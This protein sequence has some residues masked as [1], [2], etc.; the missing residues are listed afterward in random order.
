MTYDAVTEEMI[1]ERYEPSWEA[2]EATKSE[3]PFMEACFYLLKEITQW[4]LLISTS[5][6]FSLSDRNEAIRR[7]LLVRLTKLM[8]LTLRELMAK[9][10]FQQLNISRDAIETMANLIY[11]MDDD[12]TGERYDQ[13]VRNSLIAERE[14]VQDITKNIDNRD[15]R[16]LHIE[17]RMMRSIQKTAKAAGIDDV[18]TLPGR[19]QIGWPKAEDRVRLL[20]PDAYV[21]YRM[22]SGE[23]HGDWTDLYRNHLTF[24]DGDFTPNMNA[25][26]SRPQIPLM[27]VIIAAK[28]VGENLAHFIEVPMAEAIASQFEDINQRAS[29]LD[30]LHEKLLQLP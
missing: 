12:G 4:M 21:A 2:L 1:P 28:F 22:G 13:Y 6:P 27:L 19:R 7:G 5:Q 10:T 11:V 18:T 25:F 14:V 24:K 9:E 26:H 17:Q 8:R 15:D 29:K 3:A 30:A 20:G 16:A 23:T